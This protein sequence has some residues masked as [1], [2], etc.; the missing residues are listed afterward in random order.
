MQNN[1][2]LKYRCWA[3]ILPAYEGLGRGHS[4]TGHLGLTCKN[5][6]MSGMPYHIPARNL[7]CIQALLAQFWNNI[8]A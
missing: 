2:L 3:I 1:S 8:G 6:E 4:N 5:L 7:W